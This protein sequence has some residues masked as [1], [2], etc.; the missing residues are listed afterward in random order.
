MCVN[1]HHPHQK[2]LHP[3]ALVDITAGDH[4]SQH[5]PSKNPV[6][7]IHFGLTNSGLGTSTLMTLS[8]HV[9]TKIKNHQDKTKPNPHNSLL[10]LTGKAS[11][12]L[13][14]KSASNH[15]FFTLHDLVGSLLDY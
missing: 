15:C 14:I 10:H 1:Y 7:H 13:M 4:M 8:C 3:G 5:L 9:P 12:M 11:Y 2:H 6:A